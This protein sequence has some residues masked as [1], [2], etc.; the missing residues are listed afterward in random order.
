[1]PK[2][3]KKV[4]QTIRYKDSPHMARTILKTT[5]LRKAI[6]SQLA[7]TIKRECRQMCSCKHGDSVLRFLSVLEL[8]DFK[9]KRLTR[10]LKKKAPTLLTLLRAA[11]ESKKFLPS[12]SIVGMA[13]SMFLYGRNS[14]LCIPQAV[15]S[16]ILYTGHCSKMVNT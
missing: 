9:W 2:K 1:M 15:N 14:Q 16:V 3:Y 7:S 6:I 8:H 10:E 4:V 11:A 12:K 13:S 5:P